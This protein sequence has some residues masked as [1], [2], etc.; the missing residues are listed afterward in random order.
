M[1]EVFK[2]NVYVTITHSLMTDFLEGKNSIVSIMYGHFNSAIS[3]TPRVLTLL[4]LDINTNENHVP[5][6]QN[7][8]LFEPNKNEVMTSLLEQYIRNTFYMTLV[9]TFVSEIS[10]RMIAMDSATNNAKELI[11]KLALDY[12]RKRQATITK[13]MLEIIGGKEALT[14]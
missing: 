2:D 11:G 12:N 7:E 14:N 10:S 1:D 5:S 4:P 6:Y 13:E 9:N 3:N 8:P